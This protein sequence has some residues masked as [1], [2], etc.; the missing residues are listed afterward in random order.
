MAPQLP[1]GYTV[2][3]RH[4]RHHKIPH[5]SKMDGGEP[6]LAEKGG[7]TIAT[8][9][10]ADGYVVGV[11]EAI[12]HPNESYNKHLGRVVSLGRAMKHAGLSR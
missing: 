1:D 7:R 2:K 12:C 9:K 10:D 6:V 11:G 3:Y 5:P 4:V 8:L